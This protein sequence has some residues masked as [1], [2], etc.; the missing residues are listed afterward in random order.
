MKHNL[1]LYQNI[2]RLFT[3]TL[4]YVLIFITALVIYQKQITHPEYLIGIPVILFYHMLVQRYCYQPFI[5][6]LLHA[7]VYVP[8]FHFSYPIS[9]Y[10]YLYIMLLIAEDI[11]AIAVWKYN[12]DRPYTE[13]PWY[14][15]FF[16]AILYI[17]GVGARNEQYAAWVY[18]I[19]LALLVLH[20]IRY[21]LNG[22]GNLLTQSTLTTTMPTKRIMLTNSILFA[23]LITVFVLTALFAKLF[24]FDQFI[25]RLGDFILQLFQLIIH[26]IIYIVGIFR[27][28]FSSDKSHQ[29]STEENADAGGLLPELLPEPSL[30]AEILMNIIELA[31][32]ALA[33]YTLYRLLSAL[34]KLFFKR[35]AVDSDIVVTLDE[36]KETVSPQKKEIPLF[37]RIKSLFD[38]SNSAKVRL[39]YR[40]KIQSYKETVY[41]KTDTPS[42]I[43]DTVLKVYDEDISELTGVY[44][45][46]RYSDE[47]I[48]V[49]DV[50]KG[51]I[52]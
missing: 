28:L 26:C 21:F 13:A 15:F 42:D 4:V 8:V 7:A 23:F 51:G 17:A 24:G 39:A 19:G 9:W 10:L 35:Y 2:C 49:D 33:L 20:F 31:V 12:T 48:T 22:I 25:Y 43:A 27:L 50:K 18:S 5:Y 1:T 46:V 29:Q 16:V 41:R 34:V 36:K 30:F 11:H 32:L 44:E 40:L 45:K 52:L 3:V 37:S 6:I 14:L 47:E 38:N